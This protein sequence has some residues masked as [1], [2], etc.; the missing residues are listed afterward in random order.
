MAKRNCL[1]MVSNVLDR[2]NPQPNIYNIDGGSE[3]IIRLL[4]TGWRYSPDYN[5]FNTAH[6]NESSTVVD[7]FANAENKLNSAAGRGNISRKQN[8]RLH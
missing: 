8:L 2:D 6:E 1:G 3:T 5:V 4:A 7:A